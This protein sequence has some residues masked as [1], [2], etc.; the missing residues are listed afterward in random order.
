MGGFATV[1]AAVLGI[2]ILERNGIKF[3]VS[4]KN[5]KE[6]TGISA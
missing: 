1:F 4:E 5:E 6:L 3:F 2:I